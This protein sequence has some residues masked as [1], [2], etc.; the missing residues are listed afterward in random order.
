MQIAWLIGCETT[1]S[2]TVEDVKVA[3]SL[4][5]V[6]RWPANHMIDL[7]PFNARVLENSAPVTAR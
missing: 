6:A 7:A 4:C 1:H 3:L 5:V 2:A